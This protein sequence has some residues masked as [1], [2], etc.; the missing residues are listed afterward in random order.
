MFCV[1]LALPDITAI[2]VERYVF[3]QLIGPRRAWKM[4]NGNP[5]T[6]SLRCEIDDGVLGMLSAQAWGRVKVRR[7]FSCAVSHC[8]AESPTQEIY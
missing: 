3:S 5:P 4:K 6:L 2:T 1:V 8:C 7:G